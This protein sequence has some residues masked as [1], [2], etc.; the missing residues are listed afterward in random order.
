MRSEPWSSRAVCSAPPPPAPVPPRLP[1]RAREATT[2]E[3]LRSCP[4]VPSSPPSAEPR[5]DHAR[6]WD[7]LERA[8]RPWPGLRSHGPR[9]GAPLR[10]NRAR[11]HAGPGRGCD[12]GRGHRT[13]ALP[14]SSCPIAGGPR[15]AETRRLAV[16]SST[17]P[18]QA[19]QEEH[20]FL[21]AALELSESRHR[22]AA[23]SVPSACAA[24]RQVLGRERDPCG[25]GRPGLQHA[26]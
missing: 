9:V 4:A 16:L 24:G 22:G 6:R 20:A 26:R 19:R 25:H 17:R 7:P 5:A 14:Q 12:P 1:C 10:S 11:P 8:R 13:H 15:H 18:T 2:C 23:P 3:L 21:G